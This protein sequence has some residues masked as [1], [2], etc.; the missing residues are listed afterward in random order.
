MGLI[1]RVSSRTYRYSKKMN[2]I[3]NLS[4]LLNPDGA[5][6]LGD[7]R[8]GG[9][10]YATFDDAPGRPNP[11]AN[12]NI[13]PVPA[14]VELPP[15]RTVFTKPVVNA[16][17]DPNDIW[18]VSEFD[19]ETEQARANVLGK[20]TPEYEIVYKQRVRADDV[21]LGLQGKQDNIMDCEDIVVKIKLPKNEKKSE[22][23]LDMKSSFLTLS[24]PEYFLRVDFPMKINHN[25]GSAAFNKAT[26]TLS[27]TA[28]IDE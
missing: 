16:D 10:K 27:V 17:H 9:G 11:T 1:S 4:N 19:E 20:E 3:V 23:D 26:K 6:P 24:S 18:N 13:A 28:P 22:L 7:P 5:K 8:I 14:P 21:F 25:K 2:D 12:V 15:T